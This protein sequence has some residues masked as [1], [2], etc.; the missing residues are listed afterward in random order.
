MWRVLYKLSHGCHPTCRQ[1]LYDNLIFPI[2]I[3]TIVYVDVCHSIVPE[4]LNDINSGLGK[5]IHNTMMYVASSL[6]IRAF[7]HAR[8][9]RLLK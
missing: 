2:Y 8:H 6:F 1:T 9:F 5:Y 3:N 7:M 4:R